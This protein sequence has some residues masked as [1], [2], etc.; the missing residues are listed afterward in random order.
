[1]KGIFQ[2]VENE[3]PRSS[4]YLLHGFATPGLVVTQADDG[5]KSVL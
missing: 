1:M 4:L 5:G 2:I 3:E